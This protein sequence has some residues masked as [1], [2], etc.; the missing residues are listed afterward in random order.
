SSRTRRAAAPVIARTAASCSL[1]PSA[2]ASRASA[3]SCSSAN[4]RVIAVTGNDT[5]SVSPFPDAEPAH[6]RHEPIGPTRTGRPA[7]W[8]APRPRL[9]PEDGRDQG[10]TLAAAATPSKALPRPCAMITTLS[11]SYLRYSQPR[12]RPPS[13]PVTVLYARGRWARLNATDDST[14]PA[15]DP[16]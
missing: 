8:P 11:E 14:S 2:R 13:R 1:M 5:T 16:N 6:G 4:R 7:P 3:R 9:R 15:F 10:E 12:Y